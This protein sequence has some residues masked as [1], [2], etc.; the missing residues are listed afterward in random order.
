[1]NWN[2]SKLIFEQDVQN[3]NCHMHPGEILNLLVVDWSV[4]IGFHQ[5]YQ[6]FSSCCSNTVKRNWSK[7][8]AILNKTWCI[9]RESVPLNIIQV[10]SATSWSSSTFDRYRLISRGNSMKEWCI[11]FRVS[12]TFSFLCTLPRRLYYLRTKWNVW[13]LS[14]ALLLL[15]QKRMQSNLCQ[16]FPTINYRN[17]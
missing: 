10:N 2:S 9:R 12:C 4:F 13:V 1:M 6:F 7:L 5:L 16:Q 14:A 15:A 3:Q 11:S 17:I 8:Q